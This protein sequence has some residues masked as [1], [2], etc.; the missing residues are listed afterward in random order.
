MNPVTL[1]FPLV[2]YMATCLRYCGVCHNVD[3]MIFLIELFVVPNIP[4][5][6][7]FLDNI[8][9]YTITSI[10]ACYKQVYNLQGGK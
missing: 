6:I 3:D 7:G 1:G 10:L 5:I 8:Q 9:L 4:L 2:V